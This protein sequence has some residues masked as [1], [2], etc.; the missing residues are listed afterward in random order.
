MARAQ[1]RVAT[2]QKN[3]SLDLE[4]KNVG[5]ISGTFF[6][7]FWERQKMSILFFGASLTCPLVDLAHVG[8][9]AHVVG[10]HGGF[11]DAH[12]TST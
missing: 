11:K 12:D 3:R 5:A 1:T 4:V 6:R 10:G 8:D 9:L 7:F 2:S